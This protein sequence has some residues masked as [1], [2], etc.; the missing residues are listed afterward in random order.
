[1]RAV[2]SF[3]SKPYR[4][5][6][7][8]Q[9]SS[10]KHHL[11]GW[12]LSTQTARKHYRPTALYTDDA[13]AR[14]LVDGA[15]LEFDEVHTILNALS[16]H[17]PS[18][19]A[20]GKLYAYQQQDSP[21]VHLDSDVFLWKRLRDDLESAPVCAQH[22]EEFIPGR[23]YYRPDAFENAVDQVWDGWLPP[24]WVWYRRSGLPSRGESC[25]IL[26]GTR[27]D[28]LRHYAGRAIRLI[29]HPG[30]QAAWALL[31]DRV[32]HN[33]LFE[34]YLLSACVEHH[35]HHPDS[36]YHDIQIEYV[37]P[38]AGHAFNHHAAHEAGYTHLIAGSK[39]N[40][41]ITKALEA[42][43][44]ADHPESYERCSRFSAPAAGSRL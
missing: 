15:G 13:G 6:R 9:W 40:P 5:G 21:F 34:Q 32:S 44:A 28:F 38:S 3:W 20:L 30:N 10:D 22:P 37:F 18:W 33:V 41:K 39:R 8:H 42:R 7:G 35:R 11:L 17:D 16:D 19:W 2:W 1:M 31:S 12:V 43:V 23:S 25:G 29:E 24:E 27:V 26:G 14:L 36:P 4:L